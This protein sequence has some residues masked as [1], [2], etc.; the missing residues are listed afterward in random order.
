MKIDKKEQKKVDDWNDKYDV[1]QKVV[2][3]KDDG[4]K[5]ETITDSKAELLSGHTAVCWFKGIRGFYC[6]GRAKA[7]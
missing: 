2:I 5:V 3:T 6:L 1:G 4:T 7:I